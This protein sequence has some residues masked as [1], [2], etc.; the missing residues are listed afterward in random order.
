MNYAEIKMGNQLKIGIT[1][2][3]GISVHREE[4]YWRI[5][6]EKDS[7]NDKNR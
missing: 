7:F 3:T 1:A 2:P 6:V 4:V 5:Q